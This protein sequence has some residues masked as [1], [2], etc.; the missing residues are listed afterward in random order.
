MARTFDMPSAR[1]RDA[2]GDAATGARARALQLALLACGI[3]FSALYIAADI[4]LAL[5]WDGYSYR[6][7]TIS[8]FAAIGAPT[9]ALAIALGLVTYSLLI[10]FGIGVVRTTPSVRNLRIAGAALI[11]LGLKALWAVPFAPMHIRERE[12]TLTDTLHLVDGA[13]AGL[14][15]LVA[16][17]CAAATLGAP[18]SGGRFRLYCIATVIVTLVFAAWSG[19][20]GQRIADNLDTPWVGIK[21]RIAFYTLYS[22]IAVFAIALIRRTNSSPDEESRTTNAQ[23]YLQRTG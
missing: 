1:L 7:Q 20:D 8:E 23:P 21:E 4:T 22:W 12:E 6:D 3:V 11:L 18:R 16:I 5:R 10:A 9:R 13:L 19:M 14:L 2:T 15:F 17:A